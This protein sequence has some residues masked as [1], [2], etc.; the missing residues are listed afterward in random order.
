MGGD[1]SFGLAGE[2]DTVFTRSA[3]MAGC[4]AGTDDEE[5]CRR[6]RRGRRA[7]TRYL[8]VLPPA[9][10][11]SLFLHVRVQV[12]MLSARYFGERGQRGR[13]AC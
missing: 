7:D 10:F 9:L 1:S 13:W 12:E 11:L 6:E 8:G 3:G 4:F 5:S 2:T